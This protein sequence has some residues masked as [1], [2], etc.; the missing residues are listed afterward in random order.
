M[1]AFN[2]LTTAKN[3]LPPVSFSQ[4]P[5][6]TLVRVTDLLAEIR[7]MDRNQRLNRVQQG[8]VGGVIAVIQAIDGDAAAFRWLAAN[9]ELIIE[10][11]RSAL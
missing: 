4:L 3:V 5:V 8:I 7:A 11:L 10:A 1:T 2:S 6:G 9:R